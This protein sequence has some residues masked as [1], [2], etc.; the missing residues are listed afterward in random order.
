VTGRPIR[1]RLHRKKCKPERESIS[2]YS[3][4]IGTVR[5]KKEGSNPKER[6]FFG[7]N[8]DN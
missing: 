8:P 4:V 5:V 2:N 6:P 1:R 7:D 3:L